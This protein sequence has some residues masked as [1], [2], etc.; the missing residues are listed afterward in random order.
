MKK[1]FIVMD[2]PNPNGSYVDGPIL[3]MKYKSGVGPVPIPVV[4]GLT[5]GELA[6]M[7]NGEGW[8]DGGCRLE[9]LKVVECLNYD[10]QRRYYLGVKCGPNLRTQHSVYLYPSVCYFEGTVMS[11]GRGTEISFEVFGHPS[12]KDNPA[13]KDNFYFT[14]QPISG[15]R[16]PKFRGQNCYGRD[17][18]VIDDDKILKKGI[19]L[20][21]IIE[22]YNMMGA[23]GDKFFTP[24]FEKLIGVDYVRKM[25]ISGA[26]ADEIKA[27]WSKDIEQFKVLRRKY[28]RY[29]TGK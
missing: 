6:T 27:C 13:L 16:K 9:G 7:V 2:R 23:P 11:L 17:L 28:L 10:H 1:D 20:S 4:H 26:S 15:A 22:A 14:P 18:R 5:L 24:W 29:I 19:D 21:Y 25:I 12:L 8:L 3:D